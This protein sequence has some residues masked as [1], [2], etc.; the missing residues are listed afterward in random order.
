M[1]N[2]YLE[3]CHIKNK[4]ENLMCK[5]YKLQNDILNKEIAILNKQCKECEDK[6]LALEHEFIFS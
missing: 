5:Y 6:I 4:Y 1:T 3:L 2:S